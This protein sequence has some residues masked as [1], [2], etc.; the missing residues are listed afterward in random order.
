[1]IEEV[2]NMDITASEHESTIAKYRAILSGLGLAPELAEGCA[3]CEKNGG[4]PLIGLQKMVEYQALTAANDN[5]VMPHTRR[6]GETE[7]EELRNEIED[8]MLR[9]KFT[10]G[11]HRP[12]HPAD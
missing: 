2:K 8:I 3:K 1:M 10:A 7:E 12:Q 5:Q 11:Y 9:H 4:N 6:S